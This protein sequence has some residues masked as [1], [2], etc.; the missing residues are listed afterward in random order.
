MAGPPV[1]SESFT[2]FTPRQKLLLTVLLFPA[3]LASP[4]SATAYVPLLLLLSKLF[5]TS[6]EAINLTVTIYV[7]LQAISPSLFAPYADVHGRRPVLLLT[8]C[9]YTIASLGLAINDTNSYA[10]LLVLRGLQSLGASAVLSLTYGVVSDLCRPAERG[11]MVG[12]ILAM[13]SLG[14]CIGPVVGGW[15]AFGSGGVQW[16]FWALTIFGGAITLTIAL[17]FPETGRNI[18]GNGSIAPTG[19]YR[20][21]WRILTKRISN[22]HGVSRLPSVGNGTNV[23]INRT[24]SR[25]KVLIP[26]NPFFGVRIMFYKDT[27]FILFMASI[28]YATYYCVQTSIPVIYGSV[29]GFNE[30]Q[31]G[32]AYLPGGVGIIIGATCTGRLMDYNYKVTAAQVGHEIDKVRGD[33]IDKFP[34]E[35][36]R[37]RLSLPLLAIYT[38]AVVGYGWATERQPH[39]AVPLV[40]QAVL[41]LLITIFNTTYSALLVDIFP[42]NA[43]AAAATGN[44]ARCTMTGIFIAVLEPAVKIM[45]RN[46][47]FTLLGL[48][49]GGGG[50]IAVL[51]IRS[52]GRK[53]RLQRTRKSQAVEE[54][55]ALGDEEKEIS[56]ST[57]E[58]ALGIKLTNT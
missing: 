1:T 48:L 29:Y 15:I 11:T 2:T 47:Y 34:I 50:M 30:L 12:P 35:K 44:L 53:W 37:T 21:W 22:E 45:G 13:G 58:Q 27:A 31:I 20:T 49:N 54:L 5:S 10:G 42:A 36:A 46:W 57:E 4:L 24:R 14:V 16:V 41:G 33:N 55:E 56:S 43:S 23:E 7:V 6:L 17:V 51:I 32:L 40:L 26:R 18:V 38:T 9:L 3:N 39:C 19:W 28:F 25:W 8:Y 52:Q